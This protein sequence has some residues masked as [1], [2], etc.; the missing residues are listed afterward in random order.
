MYRIF[1][2]IKFYTIF[3]HLDMACC[4]I[5]FSND[6]HIFM[7]YDISEFSRKMKI[8]G[9]NKHV[10]LFRKCVEFLMHH[11]HYLYPLLNKLANH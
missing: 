9:Q 5:I 10:K 2:Y 6:P 11:L 4:I 8:W 1:K 3:S 7:R